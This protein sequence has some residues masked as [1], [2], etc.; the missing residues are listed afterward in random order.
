ML[1]VTRLRKHSPHRL[2]YRQDIGLGDELVNYLSPCL[3][4]A[5]RQ[6]HQCHAGVPPKYLDLKEVF[7]KTK[8]TSL[9]PHRPYDCGTDLLPSIT[10][11]LGHLYPLSAPKRKAM[12]KYLDEALSAGLILSFSSPAGASFLCWQK[13]CGY[14][15]MHVL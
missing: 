6:R 5:E 12:K 1:V 7:S 4:C 13:R 3:F 9:P 15:P 14:P 11:P 10:P 8:V 2:E